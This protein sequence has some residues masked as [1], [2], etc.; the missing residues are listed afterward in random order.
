MREIN[1]HFIENLSSM[2]LIY[3]TQDKQD[4]AFSED[5]LIKDTSA[6]A[7]IHNYL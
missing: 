6:N 5:K 3:L 7:I 1:S 2:S 4:I